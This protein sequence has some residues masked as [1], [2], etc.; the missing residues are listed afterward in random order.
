MKLLAGLPARN[1]VGASCV[2]LPPGPW[3]S[4]AE[5]LAVRFPSIHLM[6]WLARMADGDVFDATGKALPPDS[7]YRPHE[8]IF[9]YR[10]LP[11]EP[12]I[13]FEEHILFQDDLIVAVDKPHFLPVT[14]SG[15]Y[16][17]ETLLVRLKRT[18]GI[19]TLVPMHR[20]DR[21]TA[22][23]VLFIVQPQTRD[24]YHALFKEK[25]IH[26]RYEAVAPWRADL[27]FPLRYCSRLKESALFMQ[28]E[29]VTGLPNAETVIDLIATHGALA[30]YLLTPISG[31][32]HQLRAHMAALGMPI[33]NDRIYPVLLPA[34]PPGTAP[35]Y[36]MPL[37]LVA[38][39]IRFLD[40]ITAAVRHFDSK[41][42]LVL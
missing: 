9:Y 15:V 39:T 3:A 29:E 34:P 40:P 2:V 13:P 33:L 12:R 22:G 1:G 18:L 11:A 38:R 6:Q 14:P 21:D 4:V 41:R 25:K 8:K 36:S 26:K 42:R 27:Q 30:T 28:M 32:K 31:Q 10:S 23:V 5:F 17:Q 35:D 20:I 7:P 19:D 37:Q 16:L 24:R